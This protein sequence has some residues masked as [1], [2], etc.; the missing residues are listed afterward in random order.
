MLNIEGDDVEV[1]D[2]NPTIASIPTIAAGQI[3]GQNAFVQ[4]TAKGASLYAEPDG[5]CLTEWK[6]E[7]GNEIVTAHICGEWIVAGQRNGK[8]SVTKVSGSSITTVV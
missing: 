4:I 1:I 3:P 6:V 8:V 5:Q 7:E 2:V